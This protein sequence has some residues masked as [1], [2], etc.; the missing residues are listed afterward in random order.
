MLPILPKPNRRQVPSSKVIRPSGLRVPL[1]GNRIKYRFPVQETALPAPPLPRSGNDVLAPHRHCSICQREDAKAIAMEV[2][3]GASIRSVAERYHVSKSAL[4]RH[5]AHLPENLIQAGLSSQILEQ[6]LLLADIV[7]HEGALKLMFQEA[8][9]A[10]SRGE[11]TQVSGAL[12][13][14]FEL[15]RKMVVE[16]KDRSSQPT[17]AGSEETA[18]LIVKVFQALQEYPDARIKLAETLS[19]AAKA[20]A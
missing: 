4:A 12:L 11:A 8:L 15:L 5:V 20:T 16:Q 3:S 19:P 18:A 7:Q 6:E 2:I 9:Q 14:I 17:G 13:R 10:K 1:D